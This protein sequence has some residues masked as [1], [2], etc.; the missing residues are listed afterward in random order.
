MVV[1]L[2]MSVV[3]AWLAVMESEGVKVDVLV[4]QMAREVERQQAF[5]TVGVQVVAL[6]CLL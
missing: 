1:A 2:E 4:C 6:F 5:V 3:R